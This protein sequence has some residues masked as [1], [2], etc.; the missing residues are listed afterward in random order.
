MTTFGRLPPV[1]TERFGATAADEGSSIS[2]GAMQILAI[3]WI[4]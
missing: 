3:G 4:Q 1:A 2:S